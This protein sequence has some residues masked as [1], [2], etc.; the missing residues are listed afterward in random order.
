MRVFAAAIF[1]VMLGFAASIELLPCGE[2]EIT[3]PIT[4]DPRSDQ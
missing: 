4:I 1:G 2:L 3:D